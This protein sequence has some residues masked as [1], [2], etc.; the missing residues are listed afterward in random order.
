MALEFHDCVR[1][2]FR[3]IECPFETLKEDDEQPEDEPDKEGAEPKE[4][5]PAQERIP[6]LAHARKAESA[7]IGEDLLKLPVLAHGDKEMREALERMRSVQDRGGLRSIPRA[8][9]NL[10]DLVAPGRGRGAPFPSPGLVAPGIMAILAA[11]A[12]TATLR[13]MRSTMSNPTSGQVRASET[14]VSKGLTRLGQ[15][16]KIGTRGGFG[17]LHTRAPTFRPQLRFSPQQRNQRLKELL[18]F[19]KEPVAGFDEFSET[20]F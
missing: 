4:S 12:I 15:T 13:S 8:I 6:F 14:H 18:G 5:V 16:G 2:K 3:G 20:G 10:P 9:P 11:I 1:F 17:G 19:G 7:R